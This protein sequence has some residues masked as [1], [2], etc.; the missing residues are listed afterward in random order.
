[1]T[2]DIFYYKILLISTSNQR[3]GMTSKPSPTHI[4]GVEIIDLVTAYEPDSIDPEHK[5]TIHNRASVAQTYY[6]LKNGSIIAQEVVVP[7]S[8]RIGTGC[9]IDSSVVLA[10]N[11]TLHDFAQLNYD[12]SIGAGSVIG[13]WAM[14]AMGCRLGDNV[15]IGRRSY[16]GPENYLPDNFQL[17]P[18]SAIACE[19]ADENAFSKIAQYIGTDRPTIIVPSQWNSGVQLLVME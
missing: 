14:I 8:V 2:I 1:M 15:R 12:V 4:A 16:V 10:E 6:L 17:G 3:I 18:D 19:T 13:S 9:V 7:S 11:V 5:D